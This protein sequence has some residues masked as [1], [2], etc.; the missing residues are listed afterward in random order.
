[1]TGREADQAKRDAEQAEEERRRQALRASRE[2]WES[3]FKE[4]QAIL[5]A[6]EDFESEVRNQG[7]LDRDAVPSGTEVMHAYTETLTSTPRCDPARE[8]LPRAIG[9][10]AVKQYKAAVDLHA[11]IGTAWHVIDAERGSGS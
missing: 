9:E 7:P 1:V 2:S 3:E 5:K 4:T 11:A 8:F 10:M 6:V